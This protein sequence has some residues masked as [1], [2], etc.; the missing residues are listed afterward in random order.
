VCFSFAYPSSFVP[1]RSSGVILVVFDWVFDSN[2]DLVAYVNA[3]PDFSENFIKL[4][5][6]LLCFDTLFYWTHRLF[7]ARWSKLYKYHKDHHAFYVPMSLTGVWQHDLD[8]IITSAA[9]GLIPA[10]FLRFHLVTF[11]YWNVINIFHSCYDHAG[12]A[13]PYDPMQL[14]PF[15]SHSDSH[16]AHHSL[17][18]DNYGLYFRH[19]DLICGTHKR[20]DRYELERQEAL[21]LYRQHVAR[22]GDPK[23]RLEHG[24]FVVTDGVPLVRSSA[25]ASECDTLDDNLAFTIRTKIHQNRPPVD[26]TQKKEL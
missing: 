10:Y 18:E 3:A 21:E 5:L 20:W 16:N 13:L 24:E 14:I 11:L 25:D 9:C 17:N 26:E 12:Y 19:W 1:L 7:H 23:E 8:D 6:G 22:G 15:G 4:M 2:R